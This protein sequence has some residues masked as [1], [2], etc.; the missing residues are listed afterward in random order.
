MRIRKSVVISKFSHYKKYK[1]ESSS[2]A[3]ERRRLDPAPP[4]SDKAKNILK[5]YLI[6][7]LKSEPVS[8]DEKEF[9]LLAELLKSKDEALEGD[10]E[11]RLLSS[12]DSED[13]SL[14]PDAVEE[15]CMS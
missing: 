14:S 11:L 7:L 10:S 1:P 8:G 6:I 2:L 3:P 4:S 5:C 13:T 15:F 12:R 9:S